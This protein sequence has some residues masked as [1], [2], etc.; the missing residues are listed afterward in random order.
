MSTFNSFFTDEYDDELN[1]K[2]IYKRVI[3][4]IM[5]FVDCGRFFREPMVYVYRFIG[6][7][8]VLCFFAFMY[9]C[10]SDDKGS[11]GQYM[12]YVDGS[13]NI[14]VAL[15]VMACSCVFGLLYWINRSNS[16]R[17]KI[18]GGNDIVVM[19][20]I[21]DFVQCFF[22]CWGLTTMIFLPAYAI[23]FGIL[24]QL[25]L[26]MG[27]YVA[28]L[29]TSIGFSILAILMG[30]GT[31]CFGHFLGENI[32]AISTIANNVSDLGDIHRAATMPKEE[33]AEEEEVNNDEEEE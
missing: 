33:L 20:I 2:P 29:L 1:P 26:D 8:I 18:Q 17:T 28:M 25:F 12:R 4:S 24:G 30:Y 11:L 13:L 22:E 23:Y 21:A 16:L 7:L 3:D 5:G 32:R 14:V 15:V 31:T 19:P 9:L 10:F 6:I 27:N